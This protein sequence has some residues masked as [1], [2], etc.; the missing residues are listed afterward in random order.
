[1]EATIT[2]PASKLNLLPASVRQQ[3]LELLTSSAP[4][5]DRSNGAES[6][7]YT[8]TD[9]PAELTGGLVRKLTEKL[10]EKTLTTLRI[11]AESDHGKFHMKDVI[12]AIPDAETYRDVIGVWSAL[13]RRVRKVVG[14][15]DAYLIL[16]LGEGQYDNE[17]NYVDHEGEVAPITHQALR[18]HFQLN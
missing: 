11:I 15:Q 8:E 6:S 13:T 18:A 14:D 4:A 9:G 16:W 3:L 5:L 7:H 12:N 10:S 1:M 2:I 17:G